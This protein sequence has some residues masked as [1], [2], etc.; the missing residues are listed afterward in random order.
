[1]SSSHTLA[2]HVFDMFAKYGHLDESERRLKREPIDPRTRSVPMQS[3]PFEEKFEEFG[4][5]RVSGFPF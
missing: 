1:M 4:Y 5:F 2:P 3:T